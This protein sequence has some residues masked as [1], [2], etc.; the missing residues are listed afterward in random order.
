MFKPGS[1]GESSSGDTVIAAGVKVEGDFTSAGNIVIEGEVVGM[2]KT[3]MDLVVGPDAKI[4][5]NVTARNARVAG[6]IRGNVVVGDRLDLVGTAKITG[7][8]QAKILVV[9]AGAVLNGR[10]G[11]SESAVAQ[12]SSESAEDEPA[13]ATAGGVL[14]QARVFKTQRAAR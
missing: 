7:D 2:L 8:V 10:C 14:S 9:E 4:V 3:E 1:K 12:S 11:M 5:A 13:Q 6:E